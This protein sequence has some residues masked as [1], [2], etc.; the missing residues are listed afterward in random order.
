M[1]VNLSAKDAWNLDILD[2]P[3]GENRT[4]QGFS[5]ASAMGRRRQ[6]I[7]LKWRPNL[8]TLLP[9]ITPSKA[10]RWRFKS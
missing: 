1:G 5:L 4:A 2:C 7:A 8:G 6:E 10:I 9:K 3:K